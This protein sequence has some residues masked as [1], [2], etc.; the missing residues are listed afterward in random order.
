HSTSDRIDFVQCNVLD[1]SNWGLLGETSFDLI[2]SNPPYITL[3]EK[4]ALEP[5][6][7]EH[8][9]K[10]ALFVEDALQFYR[11]LLRLA[12]ARLQPGGYLVCEMA[13]NRHES[14]M[15][16]FADAGMSDID[17]ALDLTR[18]IRVISGRVD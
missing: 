5:E 16:L 4:D 3:N 8:E 9:P 2:V 6:V 11:V 7:S 15:A 10:E 14:V 12:K 1:E 18:K 17:M 13:A